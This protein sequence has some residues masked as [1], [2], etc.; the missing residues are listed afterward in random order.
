MPVL[1]QTRAGQQ[2][3]FKAFIVMGDYNQHTGLDVKCSKEVATAICGAILLA[4][5]SVVPVGQSYWRSK[6]GKPVL[7]HARLTGLCGS[8]LVRLLPAPRGA[9]QEAADDSRIDTCCTSPQ[10]CTATLGSLTKATFDVISKTCGYLTYE[11]W[12]EIVFT[13]SPY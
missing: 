3:M 5:L 6:I 2:T 4:K 1:K 9:A 11:L 8:V 7:S 13:K 12:K 10:G